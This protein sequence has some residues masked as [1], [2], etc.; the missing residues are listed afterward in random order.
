MQVGKAEYKPRRLLPANSRVAQLH[1]GLQVGSWQLGRPSTRLRLD[2]VQEAL[3]LLRR[4]SSRHCA[5]T[6]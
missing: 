4:S 2:S 5:L 3:L 6:E 1:N